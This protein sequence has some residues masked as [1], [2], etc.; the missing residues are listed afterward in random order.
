M[1]W[2]EVQRRLIWNENRPASRTD[3]LP[4]RFTSGEEVQRGI[5]L[6]EKSQRRGQDES[7]PVGGYDTKGQA[8]SPGLEPSGPDLYCE[9]A[10]QGERITKCRN[11]VRPRASVRRHEV[12]R[13]AVHSTEDRRQRRERPRIERPT[14]NGATVNDWPG[15]TAIASAGATGAVRPSAQTA[16]KL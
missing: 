13:R 8:V 9:A 6:H 11:D 16:W 3:R 5:D 1:G 12:L 10:I 14:D 7:A 15:R 2:D 4:E